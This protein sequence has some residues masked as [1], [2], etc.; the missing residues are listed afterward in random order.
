MNKK[1]KRIKKMQRNILILISI[2]A[3][4]LLA[5]FFSGSITETIEKNKIQQANAEEEAQIE[6]L[7]DCMK[8]ES[9]SIVGRATGTGPF[10]EAEDGNIPEVPAPG[11][12]YTDS[13]SYVRTFDVVKYNLNVSV[14]PNTDKEG[15]TDSSTFYGGII[16]VRAKL[17]N[18]GD[19]V[20]LTWER[21]AWMQNVQLSEDKTEIYAEYQIPSTQV[22][23]PN[24]Q[25]LSFTYTVGGKVTE[26]TEEQS[27]IFEVWMD[28]NKPDDENSVAESIT[29]QDDINEPIKISAKAGLNVKLSKGDL[30]QKWSYIQNE[31]TDEAKTL[32]GYYLNYGI[33]VGIAQEE[34]DNLT[35]LRGIIYP[36]GE[37]S[38]DL[39]LNYMY[40]SNG[41]WIPVDENTEGSLG[42][43]NGAFLVAYS[44]MVR[45]MKISGLGIQ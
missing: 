14:I 2:I 12:D 32:N 27:P 42:P 5:L 6:D 18:Q 19:N 26:V 7:K 3:V 11:E 45:K 40:S 13:D 41:E 1:H 44:L 22:S 20:N 9:I 21:D 23:C 16:K 39:D 33:A 38:I 29:V 8:I 34:N 10:T 31:G 30:T 35:D 4:L 37:V 36:E 17:P 43:A 28:G 24:L 15:V 25:S